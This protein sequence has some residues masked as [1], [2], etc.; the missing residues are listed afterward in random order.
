MI[1][2]WVVLLGTFDSRKLLLMGAIFVSV[3][4]IESLQS[5]VLGVNITQMGFTA[6][7]YTFIDRLSC[8]LILIMFLDSDAVIAKEFISG[9]SKLRVECKI[10]HW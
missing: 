3:V 7:L 1:G 4:D 5:Y 6:E 10:T 2:S 9:I 8:E